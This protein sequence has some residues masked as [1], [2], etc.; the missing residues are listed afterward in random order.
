ML[1]LFVRTAVAYSAAEL[2]A[3]DVQRPSEYMYAYGV[4]YSEAGKACAL[5]VQQAPYV[6]V[7]LVATSVIVNHGRDLDND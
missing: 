7:A 6:E 1:I 4:V 2:E 5:F 3:N